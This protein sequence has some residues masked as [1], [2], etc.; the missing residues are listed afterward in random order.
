MWKETFENLRDTLYTSTGVACPTLEPRRF[1]LTVLC[2]RTIIIS[3][4]CHATK[5]LY[6]QTNHLVPTYTNDYMYPC[7]GQSRGTFF[8]RR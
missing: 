8:S 7:S 4:A 5:K 1:F 6:L 3:V 2:T